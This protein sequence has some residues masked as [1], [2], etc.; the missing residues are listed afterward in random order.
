VS[1][2]E[3]IYSRDG[4][5]DATDADS[6]RFASAVFGHS[7]EGE[8]EADSD[9]EEHPSYGRSRHRRYTPPQATPETE[10]SETSNDNSIK[11]IEELPSEQMKFG[12]SRRKGR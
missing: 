8:N 12:R 5:D 7:R 9:A 1:E 10:P 11:G 6:D 2:V 3:S 4:Q